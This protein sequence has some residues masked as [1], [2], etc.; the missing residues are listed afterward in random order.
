MKI[1]NVN[2]GTDIGYW[3]TTLQALSPYMAKLRLKELHKNK[4]SFRL[5]RIKNEQ[6]LNRNSYEIDS[7]FFSSDLVSTK[8]I[9]V[10]YLTLYCAN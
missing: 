3:E 5:K 4:L 7:N 8:I 9:E 1:S 6:I 2:K 10:I